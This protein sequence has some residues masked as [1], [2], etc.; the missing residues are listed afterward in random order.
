[1]E[2]KIKKNFVATFIGYGIFFSLV[3]GTL[4]YQPEV[5]FSHIMEQTIPSGFIAPCCDGPG[6]MPKIIMYLTEHVGLHN[7]NQSSFTDNCV[8]S[9]WTKCSN[10][11]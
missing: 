11:S 9:C 8:I 1:M 7:S 6:Y 5:N 2:F 4:V 10:C 3:S